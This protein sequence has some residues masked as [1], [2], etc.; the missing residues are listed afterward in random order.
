MIITVLLVLSC[1]FLNVTGNDSIVD[2]QGKTCQ[3][4]DGDVSMFD[5]REVK[6]GTLVI[7][8]GSYRLQV[9]KEG[10]ACLRIGDNTEVVING[11]LALA[12]NCFKSCDMIRIVGSH[13]KIHGKGSI[14]GDRHTHTGREGEWGMGIRLDGAEN[15]TVSGITIANCWG[16]CIYVGGGSKNIRVSNCKLQGSRRQGISVTKA[17]G[18][19][20]SN[21]KIADISGTMPQY[22]ICIEPNKRCIV[23]NVVI[24]NVTVTGCEGGFRAVLGKST[25]DNARIGKVEIRNCHVSAKSRH[26]IHFAGCEQAVV[27]NCVIETLKGEKPILTRHVGSLLENN[28]KVIYTKTR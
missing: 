11:R 24:E 6:N 22:A 8:E 27:T 26:T 13:V 20:I 16:D 19:T 18:V 15:V 3:I 7:A 2:L 5:G 21:C 12:P 25:F 28:N 14:R 23:D 10:G 9:K 4:M 1:L 17:T